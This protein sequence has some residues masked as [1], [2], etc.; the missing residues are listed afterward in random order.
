MLRCIVEWCAAQLSKHVIHLLL[1][2]TTLYCSIDLNCTTVGNTHS[3]ITNN[4]DNI[5]TKL[6]IYV[7]IFI[8]FCVGG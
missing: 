1:N 4:I 7:H 8:V 2:T 3:L 6:H 5:T